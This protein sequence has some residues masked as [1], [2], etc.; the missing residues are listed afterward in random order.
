MRFRLILVRMAKT[1]EPRT[2]AGECAGEREA[3]FTVGGIVNWYDHHEN[4]SKEVSK[5]N[6]PYEPALWILGLCK[7]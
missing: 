1:K 3:S 6:L 4:H 7:K 2:C 5:I